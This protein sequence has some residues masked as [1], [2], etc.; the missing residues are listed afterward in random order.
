MATTLKTQADMFT[1]GLLRVALAN[2]DATHSPVTTFIHGGLEFEVKLKRLNGSRV[3][4]RTERLLMERV[5][6]GHEDLSQSE[7][8]LA[9]RILKGL[10]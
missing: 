5:K 6:A 8:R 3:L 9:R 10:P 2:L 4:S 1:T 7:V